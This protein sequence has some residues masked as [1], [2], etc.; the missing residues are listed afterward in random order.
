MKVWPTVTV[1][2]HR[3]ARKTV[4]M[5]HCV[6]LKTPKQLVARVIISVLTIFG[7]PI[8]TKTLINCRLNSL[9]KM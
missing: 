8:A 7:F 9:V 6:S 5:K 1:L 3:I 2:K 4:F